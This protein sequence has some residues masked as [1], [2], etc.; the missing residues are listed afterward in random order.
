MK[1]RCALPDFT[2]LWK[3]ERELLDALGCDPGADHKPKIAIPSPDKVLAEMAGL[4]KSDKTKPPLN[5][6]GAEGASGFETTSGRPFAFEFPW[7]K[8][9]ISSA[10]L[11]LG[12][13][14]TAPEW[15]P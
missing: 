1:A 9:L 12:L 5:S 10:I 11:Q 8:G 4:T 7:W 2:S 14:Y 15:I 6:E 13:K 3:D